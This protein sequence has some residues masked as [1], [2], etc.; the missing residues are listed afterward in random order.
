MKDIQLPKHRYVAALR[1]QLKRIEAGVPLQ[2]Y[3][4]NTVGSKSMSVSWGLCCEDKAAWPDKEDH[5]WPDQ[6]EKHGRVAPRYLKAGHTCP[7]DA[8]GVGNKELNG[9]F[10]TCMIFQKKYKTPNREIAIALF[11]ETIAG[12]EK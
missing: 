5:L 1:R 2:Y 11:K 7:F 8:R 6:F 12:V 4:D 10:Y 3:D 9:C